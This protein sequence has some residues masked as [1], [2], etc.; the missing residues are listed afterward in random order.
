M[1]SAHSRKLFFLRYVFFGFVV[2]ASLVNRLEAAFSI[3]SAKD[4]CNLMV[5]LPWLLPNGEATYTAFSVMIV[6]DTL[7]DAGRGFCVVILPNP[8]FGF[9]RHGVRP[10]QQGL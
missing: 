6:Q 3:L 5:R 9:T 4:E 2:V 10:K 7:S 8:F 1:L